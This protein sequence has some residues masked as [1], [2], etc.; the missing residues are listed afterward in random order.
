MSAV[1]HKIGL[2][3]VQFG[4]DYGITNAAGITPPAEVSKILSLAARAEIS[5]LDT[6]H[7]YGTSEEVLGR[8][9]PDDSAFQIVTK[10][11]DFGKL[12]TLSS[13]TARSALQDALTLSL[14]RLGR[15]SIYGLLVHNA[16]GLT[17]EIGRDLHSAMVDLKASG[18]VQKIGASIY[19]PEEIEPLLAQF[20]AL[21]IIQ[22]PMNLFDQ[23]MIRTGWLDR[24]KQ[25]GIEIHVRSLFLQGALLAPPGRLPPRLSPFKQQF[26]TYHRSLDQW[27]ISPL[28]ACLK[29][30]MHTPGID[31]LIIGINSE[32]QLQDILTTV[33]V[34]TAHDLDFSDLACDD[35]NLLNPALWPVAT[36]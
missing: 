12:G 14:R 7:L 27:G 9:L 5:T 24:L 6:A 3:T 1:P 34:L 17:A 31:R 11:P 29:F 20:G 8:T 30:G 4:M 22:V 15:T 32:A 21:D 28:A 26:D 23:R 36:S 18:K 19:T 13:A 25:N 33:S 10:T 35:K 2:G 16:G